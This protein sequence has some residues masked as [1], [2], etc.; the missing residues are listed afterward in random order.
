MILKT[1]SLYGLICNNAWLNNKWY[2]NRM[3][4]CIQSKF[5]VKRPPQTGSFKA[6]TSSM[7]VL[8]KRLFLKKGPRGTCKVKNR[9]NHGKCFILISNFLVQ[10]DRI[11]VFFQDTYWWKAVS[12]PGNKIFNIRSNRKLSCQ[13]RWSYFETILC[14]IALL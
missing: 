1:S 5:G 12:M 14:V 10:I 13:L 3:W 4:L 2:C 7:S 6:Q 9:N 8:S 11:C